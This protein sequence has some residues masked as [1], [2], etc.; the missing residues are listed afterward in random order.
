[1]KLMTAK[2]SRCATKFRRK[3]KPELL[4]AI[5]KHLWGK[6]KDWMT[7]RIRAGKA[8]SGNPSIGAFMKDLVSGDIIPGYAKYKRRHY[9]ATKPVMEALMPYLPANIQAGWMFIDKVA[10]KAYRKR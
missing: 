8:K 5:R 10:Q 7:A 3:T 4:G 9:E 2:C 6:H 1:M